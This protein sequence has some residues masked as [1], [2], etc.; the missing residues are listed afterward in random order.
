VKE[1]LEGGTASNASDTPSFNEWLREWADDHA[2]TKV[3]EQ[4]RN[5]PAIAHNLDAVEQE[6]ISQEKRAEMIEKLQV[7]QESKEGQ[8]AREALSWMPSLSG[9]AIYNQM[10]GKF[11]ET[12]EANEGK[13]EGETFAQLNT[14]L[15]ED[16]AQVLGDH[17]VDFANKILTTKADELVNSFADWVNASKNLKSLEINRSTLVSLLDQM[18]VQYD[19]QAVAEAPVVE[20]GA[21]DE[22][23]G[24]DTTLA[25]SAKREVLMDFL[26][27]ML[28]LME[29]INYD[30]IQEKAAERGLEAEELYVYSMSILLVGTEQI[31]TGEETSEDKDR[32]M[33]ELSALDSEQKPLSPWADAYV[34]EMFYELFNERGDLDRWKTLEEQEKIQL[35]RN[36]L[37]G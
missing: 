12:L 37:E 13:M 27:Y 25:S 14:L 7:L 22:E 20:E 21:S 5:V 17:K 35:V 19:A 33:T 11:T 32:L 36:Y 30:E 18:G 29:N 1:Y 6:L 10:I 31:F 34:M 16:L 2:T 9:D 8:A 23:E 4:V 3:H 15:K 24:E 28:P 26:S